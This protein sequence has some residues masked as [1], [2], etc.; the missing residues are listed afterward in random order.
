[1]FSNKKDLALLILRLTFGG[2]MLINH[3]WGKMQ[4]ILAGGEIEFADP[5]GIGAATS[6]YLTVFA[7]VICAAL[8]IIGF[9]TRWATLP[10]IFTMLVAIFVIHWSD[11]FGDKEMAILYLMP[12]IA[13]YLMGAGR[14]SVDGQMGRL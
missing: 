4:K 2:L 6:L 12:Y 14:Y 9:F 8:I 11:P 10:L 7:E 1:M 3:G 13:L 5:F